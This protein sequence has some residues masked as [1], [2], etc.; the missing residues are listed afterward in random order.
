MFAVCLAKRSVSA[1][2]SVDGRW[3]S[4]NMELWWN[5]WWGK[6]RR[7]RRETWPSATLSTANPTWIAM[8]L[9]SWPCMY[10]ILEHTY[11]KQVCPEV[12]IFMF[13]LHQFEVES[14]FEILCMLRRCHLHRH[15]DINYYHQHHYYYNYHHHYHHHYYNNHHHHPR[16]IW[17]KSVRKAV[18]NSKH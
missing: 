5:N 8:G 16:N 14:N 11:R 6:S 4:M 15:N 17:G 18:G 12:Y 1:P 3:M 2:Y 9:T 10:K 7:T 13:V